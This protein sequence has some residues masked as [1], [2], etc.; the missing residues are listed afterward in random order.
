MFEASRCDFNR[1]RSPD[2]EMMDLQYVWMGGGQYVPL[3]CHASPLQN[4]DHHA[5]R[6]TWLRDIKYPRFVKAKENIK[7]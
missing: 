7:N 3:S 5:Q 2:N 4:M 6:I 1:D